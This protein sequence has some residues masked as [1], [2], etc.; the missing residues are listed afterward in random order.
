MT[1]SAASPPSSPAHAAGRLDQLDG[2]RGLAILGVLANHFLPFPGSF[3][4]GWLGVNLFFVLS[5][6]LITRIL[7]E[8]RQTIDGKYGVLRSLGVFYARRA[9]RIFPLY[10]FAL[11]VLWVCN[12]QQS[13]EYGW[14]LA[15]YTYN[16][17]IA[18]V[19]FSQTYDHF[20]TLCVE[21]QFYLIWPVVLLTLSPRWLPKILGVA[22]LVGPAWRVGCLGLAATTR[23]PLH[24]ATFACLDCLAAGALLAYFQNERIGWQSFLNRCRIVG[25]AL[26][27]L[28]VV[29]CMLQ[30]PWMWH[31]VTVEWV[32]GNTAMA[33]FFAWVVGRAAEQ[34]D[35]DWNALLRMKW[36]TYL[37]TI[38]YSVY[39]LHNFTPLLWAWVAPHVRWVAIPAPYA[40][41]TLSI[42][43][44][45]LS[46]NLIER[47][48]QRLK[49]LIPYA[50]HPTGDAAQNHPAYRRAA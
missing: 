46:W 49:R 22:F 36:L 3:Y 18:V 24:V 50:P 2:L 10:Y 47:P 27:V 9:L 7:L 29:V 8:Q 44:G 33:I 32:I 42:L 19:G 21:E 43:A 12:F 14:W 37:G 20:W 11:A 23:M 30:R 35:G 17:R 6:F 4:C 39:V 1:K 41:V 38:S 5:G 15:T 34:R 13:R 26:M 48:I 28:W 25:V 16:V 40:H 45:M 31:H